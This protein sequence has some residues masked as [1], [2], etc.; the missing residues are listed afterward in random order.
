MIMEHYRSKQVVKTFYQKLLKPVFEAKD[1]NSVDGI[2]MKLF[3]IKLIIDKENRFKNEVLFMKIY[4]E[5][6]TFLSFLM[7]V[8]S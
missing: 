6:R 7:Y 1:N 4:T 3:C 8:R 5:T 2:N